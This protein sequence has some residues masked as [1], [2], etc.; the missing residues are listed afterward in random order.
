[1]KSINAGFLH[2]QWGLVLYLKVYFKKKRIDRRAV[3]MKINEKSIFIG[4]SVF[5][6]NFGYLNQ[7]KIII[8]IVINI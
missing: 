2:C 4:T 8:I 1:M 3:F 6:K 7:Q 5:H